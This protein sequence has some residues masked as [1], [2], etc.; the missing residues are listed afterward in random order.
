MVKEWRVGV[1]F[2][3][4]GPGR[5]ICAEIASKEV[6]IE[7]LSRE[8]REHHK[9][10]ADGFGG[11]RN[12]PLKQALSYIA[13]YSFR[14]EFNRRIWGEPETISRTVKNLCQDTRL[15]VG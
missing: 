13:R 9:A 15:K 6:Y 5:V 8:F 3:S 1:V 10:V 2:A 11:D 4:Q 14:L 7:V 12:R